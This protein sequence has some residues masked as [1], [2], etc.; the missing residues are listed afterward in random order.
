MSSEQN[1]QERSR[2]L[3]EAGEA[4]TDPL[5]RYALLTQSERIG[6][7]AIRLGMARLQ[8]ETL[9][10]QAVALGLVLVTR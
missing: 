7:K 1:Y 10:A 9:Q 5:L 2:R 4:E 8:A 6:H 3:F